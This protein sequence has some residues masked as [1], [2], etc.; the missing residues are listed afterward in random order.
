MLANL[1]SVL[2]CSVSAPSTVICLHYLYWP[3]LDSL[4]HVN[5]C[6]EKCISP[7]R[8]LKPLKD[9]QYKNNKDS[10]LQVRKKE[11]VEKQR[12]VWVRKEVSE[13]E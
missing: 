6:I 9:L 5:M 10:R 2:L 12:R 11:K 4:L 7:K 3:L 13:V 1:S 8:N